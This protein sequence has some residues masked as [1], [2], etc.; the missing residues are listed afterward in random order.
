MGFRRAE[1]KRRIRYIPL[2]VRST[3]ATAD[4]RSSELSHFSSLL[5]S[6]LFLPLFL[7]PTH[8]AADVRSSELSQFSSLFISLLFL[9]PSRRLDTSTLRRRLPPRLTCDRRSTSQFSSLLISLLASRHLLQFIICASST[10]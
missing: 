2:F 1:T 7:R 10:T 8:T 5:I 3:P 6:L 4:M 9:P